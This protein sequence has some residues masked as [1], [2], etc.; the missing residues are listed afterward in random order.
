MVEELVREFVPDALAAGLD[1]SRLQ[2][3]NPKFHV[4]RRPAR[5]RE[6][7]VIWRLPTCAGTDIYL[8]LLIEFQSESDWWMAVRAQVYQGLLWQQ[9]IDENRLQ[10]GARLPPLLL[11]VLYNGRQRWRAPTELTELIGLETKSALWHWQPQVR[12]YLLDMGAFAGDDL[13]QRTSLAALLFRLE[14]QYSPLQIHKMAK[15]V[16]GWFRQHEGFEA[17]KRLF[18][19]LVRQAIRSLNP[20]ARVPEELDELVDMKSNLATIGEVW[21]EQSLAEGRA[22]GRVEGMAAGKAVGRVEGRAKGRAEGKAEGKAEALESLLVKRFGP[23][24][25][26]CRKRIQSAKLATIERWLDLAI[27]AP[28][29]SSVFKPRR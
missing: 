19:E 5:R 21:R 13:A 20:R 11:L 1:F 15:E 28:K 8:Y 27:D 7:D 9:V 2:R 23:L 29:L 25:R 10:T 24:T 18:R 6:A 12:Y 17:L 3:V 22:A 16:V 26:P 14:Q 4:G